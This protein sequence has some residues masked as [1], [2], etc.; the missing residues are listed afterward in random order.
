[1][2]SCGAVLATSV[3][4]RAG[5]RVDDR[6]RRIEKVEPDV[7]G[8]GIGDG[9]TRAVGAV[10]DVDGDGDDAAEGRPTPGERREIGA[11]SEIRRVLRSAPEAGAR[12]G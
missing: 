9:E 1:M 5:R 7:D 11:A 12:R 4:G 10:F 8:F 6:A 2:N 3:A